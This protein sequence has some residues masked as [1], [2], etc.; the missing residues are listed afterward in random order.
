[1]SQ[2][3]SAYALCQS[4]SPSMFQFY[5]WPAHIVEAWRVRTSAGDEVVGWYTH[6][7][8]EIV[9]KSSDENTTVT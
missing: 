5:A 2:S 9:I 4:H 3:S 7:G 1:M 6:L 8:S